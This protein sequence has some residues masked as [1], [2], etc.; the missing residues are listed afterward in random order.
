MAPI[1]VINYVIVHE[2]VHLHEKNHSKKFWAN[3]GAIM[4]DYQQRIEWLEQHGHLL[5][6]K[7]LHVKFAKV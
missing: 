1:P 2:L 5:E 3:V 6:L 7:E 4:P